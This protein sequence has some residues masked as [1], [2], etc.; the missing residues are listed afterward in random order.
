MVNISPDIRERFISVISRNGRIF[1]RG[2]CNH[3]RILFYPAKI[4]FPVRDKSSIFAEFDMLNSSECVWQYTV[5]YI[6]IRR[7][8]YNIHPTINGQRAKKLS[9][10][11][12]KNC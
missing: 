11:F 9:H 8:I 10:A 4:L 12:L 3:V 2:A 7:K 5:D 6:V 1:S